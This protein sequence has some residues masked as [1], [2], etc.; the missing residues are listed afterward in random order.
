[1]V[2]ELAEDALPAGHLYET[3]TETETEREVRRT[4]PGFDSAPCW[5]VMLPMEPLLILPT[6]FRRIRTEA[7]R[8]TNVQKL[9]QRAREN[10]VQ[11]SF[12]ESLHQ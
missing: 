8:Q 12:G 5:L 3:E 6:G 10:P 9:E 2:R 4:R 11:S 7:G 1:L